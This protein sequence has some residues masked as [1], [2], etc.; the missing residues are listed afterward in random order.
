MIFIG[1]IRVCLEINGKKLF[2]TFSRYCLYT[3]RIGNL[4]TCQPDL[5][6]L[7]TKVNLQYHKEM[8]TFKTSKS[9]QELCS[10]LGRV[11]N[12][13]HASLVSLLFYC[14]TLKPYK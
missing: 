14:H 4:P 6:S 10:N 13:I 8:G 2:V 1:Q 12:H 7:I 5:V 3:Q 9:A 11:N